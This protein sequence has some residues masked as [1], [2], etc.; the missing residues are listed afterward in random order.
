MSSPLLSR[1][2]RDANWICICSHLIPFLKWQHPDL[3]HRCS[4]TANS[5]RRE[6]QRKIHTMRGKAATVVACHLDTAAA[7]NSMLLTQGPV[8]ARQDV[9]VHFA[10]KTSTCEFGCILWRFKYI[11]DGT[12]CGE[13]SGRSHRASTIGNKNLLWTFSCLYPFCFRFCQII[14]NCLFCFTTY[15]K[16][17]LRPTYFILRVHILWIKR[18][19]PCK[20]AAA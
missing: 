4:I 5:R 6:F 11:R 13:S 15:K 17:L 20:P 1:R 10:V 12:V 7:V 16:H 14:T 9:S 8:N 3:Q 2:W 19:P 18:R